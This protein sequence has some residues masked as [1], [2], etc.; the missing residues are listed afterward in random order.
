MKDNAITTLCVVFFFFFGEAAAKTRIPVLLV[1]ACAT[2]YSATWY[3]GSL[4]EIGWPQL[5]QRPDESSGR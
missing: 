5:G 2:Q 1:T 3:E 4:Q